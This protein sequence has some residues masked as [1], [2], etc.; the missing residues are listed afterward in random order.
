MD[1][2]HKMHF[3]RKNY[4]YPDLPKGYQIT[5]WETPIGRN[6]YLEIKI[7]DTYKKI[8]IERIHI[9]E[10]TAK[11]MHGKGKTLLNYNRSGV[12]LI[13][14]VSKPDLKSSKEATTYAEALRKLML[15]LGVSDAK[16][17]EGSIRFDVN[18]SVSKTEELGVRSEIKNI[19]S[20]SNIEKAIN[21]EVKRQST[22]LEKGEK[23]LPDTRKYDEKTESTIFM[24][25]KDTENDYRYFPEPDIPY[26][27]LT[28]NDI[29]KIKA[30]LPLTPL[31]REK[32]YL[33]KGIS[34]INIFKILNN[35]P[36]SDYI[37]N[38]LDTNI[39]F[40]VASNILLG[41]ISSYLN[42]NSMN[43][44]DINLSKD[45]FIE[46]VSALSTNKISSKT[47]KIIRT[48]SAFVGG[49][50]SKLPVILNII[51]NQDQN[52]K[53]LI[54]NKDYN[55]A[56]KVEEYIN[57][58]LGNICK[59]YHTHLL[60]ILAT[61]ADGNPICYKSGAKKGEKK[62]MCE[63]AQRTLISQLFDEGKVTVIS[64]TDCPPKELYGTFDLVIYT[65]PLCAPIS[66][67]MYRLAE[68][69][70]G[71]K[72][73]LKTLYI[74]NSIEQT[75]LAKILTETKHNI[76]NLEELQKKFIGV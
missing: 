12:P 59:A 48:R 29:E 60:P 1:I 13:E 72:I 57:E 19:G 67:L 16:I 41:D 64:T 24:R 46:L 75:K 62:M 68:L 25:Y 58:N 36:L 47:F 66:E 15:Y 32:A 2:A 34:E 23:L 18:V 14:I 49:Y 28:D 7:G 69:K 42:K 50:K 8:G 37:N 30:T 11:S 51:A 70:L 38:F 61:D 3:D 65:S 21:Y 10:D 43:I 54:I 31:E 55:F 53:I 5:Q 40:K 71:S 26:L 17:E 52:T 20:I 73:V 22:L 45:R 33:E 6:G 27:Y 9:E 44:L 63:K 74:E 39:D 56:T 35:K 4:F 76:V